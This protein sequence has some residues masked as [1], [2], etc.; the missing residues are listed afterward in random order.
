MIVLLGAIHQAEARIKVEFTCQ[1]DVMN[2]HCQS[3]RVITIYKA[4]YSKKQDN[5]CKRGNSAQYCDPVD[6]TNLVRKLCNRQMTC[7]V[8]V[9]KNTMEDKC[10][11]VF[12]YLDVFYECSK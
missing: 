2:L 11:K 1:D 5:K 7:N 4:E 10:P 8:S 6:K 9:D 3:P 12:K